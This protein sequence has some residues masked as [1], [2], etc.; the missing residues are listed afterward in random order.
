MS[1]TPTCSHGGRAWRMWWRL[2][3][4][5]AFACFDFAACGPYV[6]IDMRSGEMDGYD[7]IFLSPHKFLGG[8]GS[9]G[10]LLM[11]NSLYQLRSSPPSTCGG[12]TVNFVPTE[13][14]TL[15][16]ENIQEREDAG[17]PPIIQK[18][19]A[20]LAFW[21]KNTLGIKW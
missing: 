12:G 17:T 18:I 11:N 2:S 15:Y 13:K 14:D 5:R 1:T 16:V 21:V 8:P 10:I 3:W 19:R 6:G 4:I 9:P 20:A 7:A